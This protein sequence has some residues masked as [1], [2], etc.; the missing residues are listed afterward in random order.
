MLATA[1]T[2]SSCSWAHHEVQRALFDRH[3]S[4][5]RSGAFERARFHPSSLP[6]MGETN[7]TALPPP[8]QPPKKKSSSRVRPSVR[9]SVKRLFPFPS[10]PSSPDGRREDRGAGI[11]RRPP[12]R[13]PFIRPPRAIRAQQVRT[14]LP[15]FEN[16]IMDKI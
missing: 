15:K 5:G 3:D 11:Y 4:R 12:L 9:P 16:E 6:P 7:K 2:L 8:L 1:V 14:T 10:P 13:R